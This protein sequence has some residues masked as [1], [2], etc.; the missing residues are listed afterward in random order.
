MLIQKHLIFYFRG[1]LKDIDLK[2]KKIN[3]QILL[4]NCSLLILLRN[5]WVNIF[6]LI[7]CPVL[8]PMTSHSLYSGNKFKLCIFKF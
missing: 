2:F 1:H 3:K 8:D 5:S 6:D 7:F 4:I